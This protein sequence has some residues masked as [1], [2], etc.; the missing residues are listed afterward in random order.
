MAVALPSIHHSHID[1][2]DLRLPLTSRLSY[3]R[4]YRSTADPTYNTKEKSGD[5]I[6]RS[7]SCY[8]R[9]PLV[10]HSTNSSPELVA[11]AETPQRSTHRKRALESRSRERDS[12]KVVSRYHSPE[13]SPPRDE[14]GYPAFPTTLRKAVHAW[15]KSLQPRSIYSFG[16]L[17]DLFQK[18]FVSSRSGRKNSTSLL[19][20]VQEKNESLACFLRRFNAATLEI[21]NLEESVKYTAFLRGL[22]STSKFT[23]SVN[24]SPLGNM[25][26]LLEKANKYI[27]AEEYLETHRGRQEEG[28]EEQ[29]K[30]SRE[31]TPQGGKPSKRSKRRPK[32]PFMFKNLT[33][34]NAKPSQILHEIKDN[35]ALQWPD[36]MRYRPNKRNKELWCHYHNDHG[37]TTDNYGQQ[38]TPPEV[39]ER[40]DQEEH[41]GIINTIS[42]GLVAGGSSGKSRKAY[43]REVCITS[44][45]P[46][47]K[48]KTASVPA[49]SF[50]DEDLKDVK[51]P[52]DDQLVVTI[53]ARNF[54]VKRVLVDNGSSAKILFYDAF[55]KMNIPTDS[56]R[57]MDS[58]LYGFS[59]HSVTVEGI[60]ALPVAIGTPPTQANLMLD[61]LVVKVPSAYN[62]ILGRPALNQLQAVVSTYH[63]KMKFPTENRIR[64]VKGDQTTARQC[65]VTSCRSKNKEALIIEDLR[66]DTKMQRGEPVK[67]L[68]SIEV[69]PGDEDKTVQIGSNLKEDTKLELV[70][71]LRTYADVFAWTAAD[72]PR[73]DGEV[74]Q[75]VETRYPKIDRIALALITSARRLRPYFQSHSIIV[76]TDQLLRKV[77]LSPEASG[78]LVNW[79][80]ELGEFDIQ[81]KPHT[82]IK[83]Q[84][85]ADFIVEC[86]LPEDPPQLVISEVTD[87]WNLYVDGSSAIGSSGA[88]IILI[89]SEGFTI[90][91]ALRFGF[92]ASNNEAEYEAL[93]VGIRLAHA[94]RVDS[95]SV[96]SDSQLV[97][98]HV[99]G[100]YEA[101]DERM[102]QYLEPASADATDVRRSVYLEFLKD[103]SISSQTEIGIIDKE[104]CWMDTVIKFLSAGELPYERHEAR[105]LCV[106]AARYALVE[107]VL[108]KKSFSLPYLRCL[109]PSESV[110]AL[111]EVHEGICGQHHGGRTLAQKILR[112]GYYWP[113]MQK[114]AIEF[115][116]RYD[117]CQN[118][119]PIS[120]TPVSPLTSVVSPIPFSMWG[121]DLLGPFPMASGQRWFVV[122]AIDYFTK[123]TEA[124]SLATI[125]S[126]KCEDF[127]WKNV[128]CRFG[129]PRALVIDNGKQFN[130][131]NF[132]T[133]CTNLLID[134]RFTS[135]AH[136]QSNGQTENM[137]RS[138]LQGLKK[139]L[140]LAKGA[141]VDELSKVLWA[142]RTTPHSVTGEMPFFLCYGTEAL[143][144]VGIGVPTMRALHFNEVNNEDGLRANL[145]LVEEARTQAHVRSVVIKQRV[146][147]YYNQRVRSRQFQE[148]DLVLR[149]LEVSDPKAATGKL[150]PN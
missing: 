11:R 127:F 35:K 149:K 132:R 86:T 73:I 15:F 44:Q 63:L 78:R 125:T 80:V 67:N 93:L 65:Y 106:R 91:Y 99:L 23:F 13:R 126:A 70:N 5:H 29:K 64:E 135:V 136:P 148:G 103:R 77:L 52:H 2:S 79:S 76:L 37:H 9:D 81:Y 20:I 145:D 109:R 124:E 14:S 54:E 119:A 28:K 130:N 129:V 113:T 50:S 25:K 27:Q 7:G 84:A 49:I 96:H 48:Q 112:Q 108:Y 110:Y 114:D 131:N 98:N 105:N 56:L 33:P 55:K 138:I 16:Q 111:Q 75:D 97:V 18:H 42:G 116:R 12:W 150:S 72:M 21:D 128:V 62:A 45:N 59:N 144:P 40:E 26:A 39:D 41:A 74:L 142:Y 100:D 31:L 104:P 61:F 115:T 123:W 60:I 141:W 6:T 53:K 57:K 22:Q 120:H 43:A 92:Q 47:K 10:K 69:Y 88:R 85:L 139:K 8:R 117:K 143:L 68:I 51:T 66:E 107:G 101:R 36:K 46:S 82:A 147:R 134:L 146:A 34:L 89:S 137:N 30:R 95:L 140:D 94:L 102:A 38:Q 19:N 90:E 133:F 4:K 83:A 87:P 118:F 122:V 17:S 3:G 71:L 1:P 58:P 121:M 24:K 32:D